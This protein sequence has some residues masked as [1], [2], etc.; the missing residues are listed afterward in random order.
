MFIWQPFFWHARLQN[1][2]S[3]YVQNLSAVS[4]LCR[5]GTNN[6]DIKYLE[7]F[8]W[9]G[10]KFDYWFFIV[11][12]GHWVF[13]PWL[14]H[15]CRANRETK[16]QANKQTIRFNWAESEMPRATMII[17]NF[18]S[19]SHSIIQCIDL[20][21]DK[22]NCFLNG[23]SRPNKNATCW[24]HYRFTVA[25]TICILKCSAIKKKKEVCIDYYLRFEI[26]YMVQRVQKKCA[27]PHHSIAHTRDRGRSFQFSEWVCLLLCRFEWCRL[28]CV[29]TA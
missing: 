11:L 7:Q 19:P 12:T 16:T 28:L 3:D 1:P 22:K 20:V 23:F 17:H 9:D 13:V 24:L 8:I 15:C 6:G 25:L 4:S 29:L 14:P 26:W 5:V 21:E 2:Y 18:Q 10:C 27:V